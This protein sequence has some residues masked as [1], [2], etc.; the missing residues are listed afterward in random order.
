MN[1]GFEFVTKITKLF[2]I[3]GMN[4]LKNWIPMMVDVLGVAL[5]IVLFSVLYEL[6][7]AREVRGWFVVA[8]AYLLFCFGVNGLKKLE[9]AEG[10]QAPAWL[11]RLD[12]TGSR[13]WLIGLG[14]VMAVTVVLIQADI[15]N[16]IDS[17]IDLM[18]NAGEVHEGEVSLYYSFGPGFLWLILG[19]FYV[20]V[21]MTQVENRITAESGRYLR[22]QLFGLGMINVLAVVYVAYFGALLARLDLSTAAWAGSM[23]GLTVLFVVVFFPAR[24]VHFF[25]RPQLLGLMSFTIFI[26]YVLVRLVV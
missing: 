9:P 5:H 18:S 25:K 13:P 21:L 7:A 20:L 4:G 15:N 12:F 19:L 26:G 24:L 10:M 16:L 23:I 8:G 2:T 14:V 17:T 3:G 6:F 22:A 11:K 1:V